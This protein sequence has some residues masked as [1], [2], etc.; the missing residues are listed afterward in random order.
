MVWRECTRA[1]TE[2]WPVYHRVAALDWFALL[3]FKPGR[4]CRICERLRGDATRW[5]EHLA[6]LACRVVAAASRAACATPPPALGA[7]VQGQ[8]EGVG[9]CAGT[10]RVGMSTWQLWNAAFGGG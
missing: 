2:S 4:S 8:L 9:A 7:A 3:C 10:P 6:T 5:D 1:T